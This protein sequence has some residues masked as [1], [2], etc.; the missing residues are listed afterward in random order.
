MY[1]KIISMTIGNNRNFLEKKR[2]LFFIFHFNVI[3][4]NTPHILYNIK[5]LSISK[6]DIGVQYL[7]SS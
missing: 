3:F 7:T 4:T 2:L 6:L 1:H 5:K